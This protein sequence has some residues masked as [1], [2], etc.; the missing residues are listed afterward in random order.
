MSAP[1][2]ELDRRA[3]PG[4]AV[5]SVA[6][7]RLDYAIA[8]LAAGD[9]SGVHEARKACKQLRGL[10]RLVRPQLAGAYRDENLRLRDAGRALSR[11]REAAV[12]VET[13]DALFAGDAELA[14]LA[15]LIRRRPQPDM[16]GALREAQQRLAAARQHAAA[17]PLGDLSAGDLMVGLLAGYRRARRGY[18]QARRRP[19]VLVL[20]EWRK[21]SKYHGY[22]CALLGQVWPALRA[23]IKPLKAQSDLLGRHHD[24]HVLTLALRR[25]AGTGVGQEL[26]RIARRRIAGEQAHATREALKLG[27]ALYVR[28]PMD[29]LSAPAP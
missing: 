9:A 20:H 4:S 10:L 16:A 15:P 5:R 25:N 19:T 13:A 3:R 24:L 7:A 27:K 22:Q 2:F 23:R 29:W 11:G 28:E 26:A 14:A 17:W 6:V 21:Q 18:A 12:L 8:G 1:R